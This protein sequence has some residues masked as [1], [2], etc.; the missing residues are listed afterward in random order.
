MNP[1]LLL[2]AL[3]MASYGLGATPTSYWVGKGLFG[4]DLRER[5][6]G[7]LGATNVYRVLG[8]KAALPVVAVD[9]FKGWLPVAWF[10]ALLAGAAATGAGDAPGARL[11]V[12]PWAWAPAFGAFAIVG[13]VFSFWVGFRGGKGVATSAGVFLGLA[14]MAVL[15]GF[16][17]WL[18]TVAATRYV[19]LGSVL[20]AAV[21]PVA[22]FLLPHRG[23]NVVL[24]FTVALAAFVIWAH[25]A[26]LGRLRRGEENRIGR[27]GGG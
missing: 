24:A 21:L 1:V 23:G 3:L 6:S 10:P 27:G 7:N 5:G 16:V 25:R 2:A 11:L 17:V 19:S 20:A 4:V 8:W 12:D 9:V 14:P 13:H 18:V 22:V 15:V 26:N